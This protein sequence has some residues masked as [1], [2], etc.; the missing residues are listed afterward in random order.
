MNN[1]ERQREREKIANLARM[2]SKVRLTRRDTKFQKIAD[3]LEKDAFTEFIAEGNE[4]AEGHEISD[5]CS[6]ASSGSEP[7][8]PAFEI[9]KKPTAVSFP[10]PSTASRT[11]VDF[12]DVLSTHIKDTHSGKEYR[13][14]KIDEIVKKESQIS[15]QSTSSLRKDK[16]QRL[17]S[18]FSKQTSVDGDGMMKE[19]IN[20]W[21]NSIDA[22]GRKMDGKV[23][24][25]T[26]ILAKDRYEYPLHTAVRQNLVSMVAALLME[27]ADSHI[28][29][30]EG[31]TPLELFKKIS[32]KP[33][34]KK[35]D[36]VIMELLSVDDN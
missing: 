21:L 33:K 2:K 6:R 22:K 31:R 8:S 17:Q 29:D 1:A 9:S 24:V 35:L 19:Y 26:N 11:G 18:G 10:T 20:V 4:S 14:S 13:Q 15:V 23:K 5:S 16:I 7:E 32:A 34:G 28:K 27:E 30:S 3:L 12:G 36:P 25:K